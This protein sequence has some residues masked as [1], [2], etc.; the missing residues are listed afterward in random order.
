MDIDYTIV[1]I[2]SLL[3]ILLIVF[4]I[5]RNQKDKQK[6]EKEIIEGEMNPEKHKDPRPN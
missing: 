6:L 2:V 5:R 4:L 1:A 3:V